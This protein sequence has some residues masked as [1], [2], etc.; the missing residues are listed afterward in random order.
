MKINNSQAGLFSTGNQAGR[1]VNRNTGTGQGWMNPTDGKKTEADVRAIRRMLRGEEDERDRT[2][3]NIVEQT[4]SYSE[5]LRKARAK[6]KNTQMKLKKLRYSFKSISTQ[7]LRSKTSYSAKQ[8][9]GKARREVVRLKMKRYTGEYDSDELRAAITHAEAMLRVA[10]KKERH[11]LEEELVKVSGGPCEAELGEIEDLK[12]RPAEEA[13]EDAMIERLASG[14][15][16]DT[17]AQDDVAKAIQE[18][19]RTEQEI[20]QAQMAQMQE[21]MRARMEELQW[22]M[23]QMSAELQMKMEASMTEMSDWMDEMSDS[24]KELTEEA[25]LDELAESLTITVKVEMDPADYKMMKIKHRSEELRAIAEADAR[26]LRAVFDKL[27]RS[28]EESV[29]AVLGANNSQEAAMPTAAA[30]SA[31]VAAPSGAPVPQAEPA[32]QAVDIASMPGDVAAAPV[33]T[34]GASVD[35]SL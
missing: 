24:M 23:E 4:L 10:K 27:E 2:R 11:L 31:P 5:S 9:A 17:G 14:E 19:M 32:P 21:E 34:V 26:Y 8:V 12:K 20:M 29:Q 25:G 3:P 30:G 15:Q 33:P 35:V 22:A 28:K 6:T 7:I 1:N 13:A 16:G 18:Q